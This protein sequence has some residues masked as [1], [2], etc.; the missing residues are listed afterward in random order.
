MLGGMTTK[1]TPLTD[2]H[3]R[4]NSANL[5]IMYR[6]IHLRVVICFQNQSTTKPLSSVRPFSLAKRITH[7]IVKK[8]R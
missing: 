2:P 3:G 7:T 6:Y 1:R 4:P 5:Q 8:L